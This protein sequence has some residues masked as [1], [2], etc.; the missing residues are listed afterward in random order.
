M[1]IP[2]CNYKLNDQN[3]I[4][5]EYYVESITNDDYIPYVYG[6]ILSVSSIGLFVSIYYANL[7]Y[8]LDN[9]RNK[10]KF[11]IFIILICIFLFLI[12]ISGYYIGKY[13]TK[14]L[15]ETYDSSKLLRPCY[16]KN[17]KHIYGLTSSHEVASS[18]NLNNILA[19]EIH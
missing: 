18:H 11:G 9:I 4:L 14:N 3:E 19:E 7:I 6:F 12:G 17:T 8:K 5:N 15:S 16:S 13:N 1:I 10:I 2:T